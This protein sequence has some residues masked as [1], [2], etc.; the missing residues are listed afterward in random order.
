V[1]EFPINN[2]KRRVA[3]SL[4][5]ESLPIRQIV[6]GAPVTFLDAKSGVLARILPPYP[7]LPGEFTGAVLDFQ[8]DPAAGIEFLRLNGISDRFGQHVGQNRYSIGIQTNGFCQVCVEA[9]LCTEE[10]WKVDV[11]IA[12]TPHG[13]KTEESK[14]FPVTF[15]VQPRRLTAAE[16]DVMRNGKNRFQ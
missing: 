2:P 13:S 15:F 7:A 12:R 1:G 10:T 6:N 9:G 11:E 4:K 16:L 5:P 3:K 14:S 8:L